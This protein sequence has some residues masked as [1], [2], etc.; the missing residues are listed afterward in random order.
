MPP[1][2]P[3]RYE[4]Y[5]KWETLPHVLNHCR[6]SSAGSGDTMPSLRG[7]RRPL[8]SGEKSSQSTRKLA[9]LVS[10]PILSRL[11]MGNSSLS[12]PAIH[13]ITDLSACDENLAMQKFTSTKPLS[14]VLFPEQRYKSMPLH[15]SSLARA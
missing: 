11:S 8:P 4:I 12:M 2:A 1:P 3:Y 7:S 13:S 5:R 10:V 9:I 6:V 15:P 14:H